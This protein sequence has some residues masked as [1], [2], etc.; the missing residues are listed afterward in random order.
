MPRHTQRLW[1]SEPTLENGTWRLAKFSWHWADRWSHVELASRGCRSDEAGLVS[2]TRIRTEYDDL[3]EQM[4]EVARWNKVLTLSVEH[5]HDAILFRGYCSGWFTLSDDE[6]KTEAM[7]AKVVPDGLLV[8]IP[9]ML[10]T[11]EHPMP[12]RDQWW[13]SRAI[14]DREPVLD[15]CATPR[16]IADDDSRQQPRPGYRRRDDHGSWWG[17]S[18]G[19]SRT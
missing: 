15:D 14:F 5:E 8:G 18:T 19:R 10:V 12:M 16:R 9:E 4:P 17:D 11:V 1:V 13:R 7:L 2:M 6:A 3:I